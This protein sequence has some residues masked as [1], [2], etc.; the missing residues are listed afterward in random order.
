MEPVSKVNCGVP[1]TVTSSENVTSM[2]IT[3]PN[4]YVPSFVE[5]VSNTT[6]GIADGRLFSIPP[7][8]GLLPAGLGRMVP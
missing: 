3:S 4:L 2:E 1:E 6:V 8:S 5:D 7:R